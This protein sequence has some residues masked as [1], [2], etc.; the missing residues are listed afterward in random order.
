MES[1]RVQIT[2][3]QIR[4]KKT[5]LVT[6]NESKARHKMCNY[7]KLGERR[8]QQESSGQASLRRRRIKGGLSVEPETRI[9][10]KNLL[11]RRNREG[12]TLIGAE[13]QRESPQTT[14]LQMKWE[15]VDGDEA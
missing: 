11:G 2:L 9:W 13:K 4:K 3:V 12:N 15:P 8:L 6:L 14:P 5:S 7:E 10:E 1:P